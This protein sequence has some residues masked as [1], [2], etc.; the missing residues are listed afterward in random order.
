MLP[1][2][3]DYIRK[4]DSF[5]EY[6]ILSCSKNTL[7][8]FYFMLY[9]KNNL[10]PEPVVTINV[11]LKNKQ[12]CESDIFLFYPAI[13]AHPFLKLSWGLFI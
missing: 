10:S 2:W 8:S 5:A 11:N 13:N 6:A 4:F 1:K 7:N 9:G 3:T 12:V